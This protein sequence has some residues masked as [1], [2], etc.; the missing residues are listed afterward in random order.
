M[1]FSPHKTFLDSFLAIVCGVMSVYALGMSVSKPTMAAFMATFVALGGLAGYGLSLAMQGTKAYKYDGWIFGFAVYLA[2]TQSGR[3]NKMLPEEGLPFALMAAVMMFLILTIGGLFAWR[4]GTLLF[5]SLPS[6]ALFGLVGTIDTWKPSVALF[7]L[8][9]VCLA[10]LYART[11]QR[12]VMKKAEELGADVNLLRRDAWKWMAGPEWAFAA[13]GAIILLSFVGAPVVQ[14]S[15]QGVTSQVK[16]NVQN[17]IRPPQA[18]VLPGASMAAES[19]IGTGPV[20]LSDRVELK[21]KTD[22]EKFYLR[23]SAFWNYTRGGWS[24]A[25]TGSNPVAFNLTGKTLYHARDPGLSF[26]DNPTRVRPVRLDIA[27][28]G[29]SEGFIPSPGL[30]IEFSKPAE[31]LENRQGT[32]LF[33]LADRPMEY[34]F[35]A[36]V[37]ESQNPDTPVG[38]PQSPVFEDPSVRYSDLTELTD[39]VTKDAKSGL[40]RARAIERAIGERCT[41]NTQAAAVPQDKD[42]VQYFLFESKQG[43]CDL[44]ASAFVQMATHAGLPTRYVTGWVMNDEAPDENGWFDVR[45]M[46]RHAWAEVYFE[47]YGWVTFDPTAFAQD[48][49][50]TQADSPL[51]KFLAALMTAGV[52]N[53]YW[54]LPLVACAVFALIWLRSSGKRAV[55]GVDGNRIAALRIQNA[56]QVSIEKHV[57]FPKRFSQSIREYTSNAAPYIGDLRGQAT[58]VAKDL[59]AAMFGRTEPSDDELKSLK[60]KVGMFTKQ[61]RAVPKPKA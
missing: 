6:I 11:Y 20:N 14:V 50:P 45:E 12:Q 53:A 28:Q 57:R 5:L 32:L 46:D 27:W 41:Y 54:I 2:V 10:V 30:V 55:K 34:S 52:D 21:V 37:P 56:F 4:D 3:V 24:Q 49:T 9:L 38:V 1:K 8:F 59:E 23:R 35:V 29:M 47:D 60:A 36:Q 39:K 40:E 44:F 7:C 48:V 16:L 26:A 43:Y 13:A 18:P 33:R 17:Q 51:G 58:E 61:L 42:P 22:G 25:N 19:R 15:L 31:F